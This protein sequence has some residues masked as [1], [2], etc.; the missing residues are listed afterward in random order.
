[1]K[2]SI[3]NEV[4]QDWDIQRVFKYVSNIGYDGVEIAPFTI[5]DNVK[6]VNAEERRRI[7]KVASSY[8]IEI[9]GIHWV[10]VGPKGLHLTSPDPR[11]RRSTQE[12]ICELVKFNSDIGGRLLV[13]GSPKQRNITKGVSRDTAWD[14]TKQIF[15]ECSQFAEDHNVLIVL[16][17]LRRQMT[18]FINTAE[19]AMKLVKAVNHPNF[20]LMLDVYSMTDEGQPYDEIIRG[21]KDYL[22]HFHANDTNKRGPG[23]GSAD[24]YNIARTL[25][26]IKYDGFVSVEVFTFTPGPEAIAWRSLENLKRFFGQT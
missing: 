5:S 8:N 9:V 21:S 10:L 6:K 7:E 2:F 11:V 25:K 24:Y 4:F 20:K 19:E 17:P 18:N 16:E 22:V 26:E 13:F 1:M 12:Y 3:C 15:S 14:Y 23:F